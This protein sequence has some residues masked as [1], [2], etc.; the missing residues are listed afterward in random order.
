MEGTLGPLILVFE[1][2]T[3]AAREPTGLL[4]QAIVGPARHMPWACNPASGCCHCDLR[5]GSNQAGMQMVTAKN[6][7]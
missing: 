2:L 5:V 1:W 4:L 3:V 6:F 7:G